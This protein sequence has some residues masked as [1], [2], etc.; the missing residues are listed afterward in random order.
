MRRRHLFL[1]GLFLLCSWPSTAT[2]EVAARV[3]DAFVSYDAE[4]SSW[5]VG[6]LTIRFTIGFD[7]SN[8]LR[9]SDLRAPRVASYGIGQAPGSVLQVNGRQVTLQRTDFDRYEVVPLDHGVRLDL[10]FTVRNQGVRITRS[11][12]TYQRAAAIEAWTKF[13]ALSG[14]VT[15]QGLNAW[16]LS[17]PSGTLRT[18]TGLRGD[19]A[20]NGG[21]TADQFTIQR[22][23][24]GEG[25]RLDFG[26]SGRS[27]EE[28]LPWFV[29][30]RGDS[31]FFGGL[32]W[33]GSWTLS[34]EGAGSLLRATM[35]LGTTATSAAP[36]RPVETPHGFFGLTGPGAAELP[37]ALSAFVGREG[38]RA[39]RPLDPLVTF[40]TWFAYSTRVDQDSMNEAIDAAARVG[41]DLFVLDAGWYR[42]A[43]RN[44]DDDFTSGLG[45][46][47]ADPAR[48]PS[49]LRSLAERAEALGL[50]FGLWVEP[51]RVAAE[52]IG[53]NGIDERW[54]A[55]RDGRY[56][57]GVSQSRAPA[58]QICLADA[59]ARQ[60]VLDRLTALI[61]EVH[62]TYLKWDNNFW[63]NC[64]RSGHGHGASDGNF[65]HVSGLYEILAT[66]RQR[67]PDLLIENCSGGG[68]RLD[69]G[70]LRYTDTAWMDDRSVPS[71]VVRH[72]LQG[73][74]EVFPPAYLLSFALAAGGE[75]LRDDGNLPLYLRSRMP[76]ILGLTLRAGELGEEDESRIN[77]EI[78]L[79][80]SLLP[81]LRR[82]SGVL[83]TDQVGRT[84][85]DWDVAESVTP[86]GRAVIFA[87]Q[88]DSASSRITVRPVGLR[89]GRRY[90]VIALGRGP[91]GSATGSS[92][93]ADG[94]EIESSPASAAQIILLEPAVTQPPDQ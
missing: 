84:A 88:N 35:G 70:M 15:L 75:S 66:L 28:N 9:V 5:T 91:I 63:I 14:T 36:G 30:E 48:F 39:G 46:Y 50:R 7:E 60:W 69:F 37:R 53:R 74:S 90:D 38:V 81:I 11:Y 67:Y 24:V 16:Q 80:K 65:A 56:V 29:V 25:T 71:S 57:P 68:N 59:S 12:A 19:N 79:Y 21:G 23:E 26:S 1:A 93:M 52:N 44:G 77:G 20:G 32:M 83:L 64:N 85:P 72:N 76:G 8:A 55:T 86:S 82:S 58:A 92:L 4:A 51:E 47:T 41:A 3:G 10:V 87:Y 78:G 13:E 43:G 89:L 34:V 45:S 40:N 54:L 73:L 62:P 33:S 94:L 18:I 42:G 61:D 17:V 49:G 2:P 31:R 6:N 22:T 27:S